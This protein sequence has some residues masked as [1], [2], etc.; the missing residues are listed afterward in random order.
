MKIK[1]FLLTGL[2]FCAF[3]GA[4][5]FAQSGSTIDSKVEKA[6]SSLAQKLTSPVSVGIGALTIQGQGAADTGSTS[7]LASYL[8]GLI[9]HYAVNVGN[10]R[11]ASDQE[12]DSFT[13]TTNFAHTR[14]LN[15]LGSQ[16]QAP[17]IQAVIEGSY[18]KTAEG[19]DVTINLSATATNRLVASARFTIP[20]SA[21]KALGL[22]ALPQNTATTA[23]FNQRQDALK[24]YAAQDNKAKQAFKLQV[25]TG[26]ADNIYHT[27]DHLVLNLWAEKDCY[28]KVYDIDVDNKIQLIYPNASDKDN[29]LKANV[30]RTIPEKSYF[31]LRPPYGEETIIVIASETPLNYSAQE[32]LP[33]E[34][35]KA[36][37][38]KSLAESRGLTVVPTEALLKTVRASLA[39][40]EYKYTVMK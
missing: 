39:R 5:L 40:A 29:T 12:M 3:C 13:K 19:F 23:A 17:A 37:A 7:A 4:G 2:C 34:F 14:S 26:D 38:R 21:V 32:M 24:T 6:V 28:F 31:L 36:A 27:G 20:A 25:W 33:Q 8:R 18:S 1:R 16:G 11:V 10:F 30:L 22:A 9:E 35:S 15:P